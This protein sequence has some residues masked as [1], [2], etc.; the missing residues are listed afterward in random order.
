MS[1]IKVVKLLLLLLLTLLLQGCWGSRE[2]DEMAYVL[3]MGFDKGPDNNIIVTF[4]IANPRAIA[5]PSGGGGGKEKPL[6]TL[7]VEA[8]LPIAAFNLLNVERS[9]Q[10]SLLHANAF[11]F[12]EELARQ[13]LEPSL[14]ALNRY[15]ETRGTAFIFV[16]RGKAR[17]FMEKNLP[18]LEI[19]P[20]K[21]Y[22]LISRIQRLHA[23]SPVVQFMDFYKR[24]KARDSQPLA[25]LASINKTGMQSDTRAEREKLGNYLAGDMP[26]TKG[27]AQFL[28][29]AVFR[30]DRMVGVLTGD[31]TRYYNM[32]AGEMLNSF[33][34]IKDPLDE[35]KDIGLQLDQAKKPDIKVLFTTEGPLIEVEIFQEPELVGIASGINYED[36][37]LKK[38]LENKLEDFIKIRCEE[39]VARTQEEFRSD[40]FGFGRYARSNF[41]TVE[42]WR[43]ADWLEVYPAARVNIKVNA[44]IRR[45]G[46]MAKTQPLH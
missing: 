1:K 19:S 31:E 26:S 45:T 42:K 23:L 32:L 35:T 40:I 21:Q 7:S 6:L 8:P 9:R 37:K 13:G 16:T 10:A 39:L 11:I 28:G 2:T 44:V 33:M 4:Q 38:I 20:S 46:L 25:P 3:V 24:V 17:D 14:N 29:S 30:E 15:R 43:Q 34:I 41:L 27:E 18:E 36:V 12:S 5:S 22:E